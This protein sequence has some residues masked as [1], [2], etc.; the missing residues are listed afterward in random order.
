MITSTYRLNMQPSLSPLVVRVSQYDVG[1]TL[2]FALVNTATSS[3]ISSGVSAEING[4]KPDGRGFTY[5]ATYSSTI[6]S[7][8]VTIQEQ[9][10]AVA[11]DVMCEI[12]LYKGTPP[13]AQN[14]SGTNYKRLGTANFILSVERAALDK[15]TITLASPIRQFVTAVD[16]QDELIAIGTEAVSLM[17]DLES[18]LP[19]LEERMS[20]T[21]VLAHD[22]AYRLTALEEHIYHRNG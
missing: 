16:Q 11:G 5:S 21:V 17:S 18:R 13:S 4:T 19:G 9:M 6:P 10:T 20:E 7:V 2:V 1:E 3:D 22:L 12:T 8:S 15:D 14:P